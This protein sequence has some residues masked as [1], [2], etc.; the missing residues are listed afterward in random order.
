MEAEAKRHM[1]TAADFSSLS[2]RQ[3]GYA[4]YMAGCRDDQPNI[5]DERNPYESE[6]EAWREWHEGQ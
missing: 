1:L 6:T 5:P 4:V 2:P 3:R